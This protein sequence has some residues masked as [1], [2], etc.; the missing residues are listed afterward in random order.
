M[1]KKSNSYDFGR[2]GK[3]PDPKFQLLIMPMFHLCS[4]YRNYPSAQLERRFKRW[5]KVKWETVKWVA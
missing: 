5:M 1:N 2:L 4:L 3:S